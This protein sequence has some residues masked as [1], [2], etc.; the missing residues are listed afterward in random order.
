MIAF[1]VPNNPR[2]EIDYFLEVGEKNRRGGGNGNLGS[3][4]LGGNAKWNRTWGLAIL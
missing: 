3:P 1:L 4:G 2:K